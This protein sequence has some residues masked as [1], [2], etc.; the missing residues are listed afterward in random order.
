MGK[1]RN[2]LIYTTEPLKGSAITYR[3]QGEEEL[4]AGEWVP[5]LPAFLCTELLLLGRKPA[6]GPRTDV[7]EAVP[8]VDAPGPLHARPQVSMVVEG[9]RHRNTAKAISPHSLLGGRLSSTQQEG[10]PAMEALRQGGLGAASHR[11]FAPTTQVKMEALRPERARVFPQI[12]TL[13]PAR[14]HLPNTR[15]LRASPFSTRL[16]RAS[17]RPCSRCLLVS[18]CSEK[19]RKHPAQPAAGPHDPQLGASHSPRGH[20]PPSWHHKGTSFQEITESYSQKLL[21]TINGHVTC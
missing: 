10:Q 19:C 6:S 21:L 9:G 14:A 11:A 15:S 2:K 5:A 4:K 17:S 1:A 18:P 7:R 13:Q 12:H 16:T 3:G 20:S 8:L